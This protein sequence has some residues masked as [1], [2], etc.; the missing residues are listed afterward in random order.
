M[1][2]YQGKGLQVPEGVKIY[3]DL[4]RSRFLERYRYLQSPSSSDDKVEKNNFSEKALV[5]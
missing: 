3:V 4:N 1:G 5:A 2:T